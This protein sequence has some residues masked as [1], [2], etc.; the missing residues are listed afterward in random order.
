MIICDSHTHSNFSFDSKSTI[1][2]MVIKAI[3]QEISVYT[4]T[5]HCDAIAINEKDNE[6]GVCLEKNIPLSVEETRRVA[7]KYSDKIKVLAGIELG[8]PT[9]FI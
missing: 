8:E 6:F 5:D 4:V 9:H 2:E 1:E 3:K 7:K